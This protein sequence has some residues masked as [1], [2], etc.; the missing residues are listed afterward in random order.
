MVS[1]GFGSL[2]FGV[3]EHVFTLIFLQELAGPLFIQKQGVDL[4]IVLNKQF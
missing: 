1:I 2:N 4:K 3:I